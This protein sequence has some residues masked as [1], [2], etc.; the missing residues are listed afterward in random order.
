M[1]HHLPAGWGTF[2]LQLNTYDFRV[3]SVL[4]FAPEGTEL[5]RFTGRTWITN[6]KGVSGWSDPDMQLSLAEGY[7]VR[8]R[9]PTVLTTVGEFPE[10][11]L[12]VMV[13]RGRHWRGSLAPQAGL[14]SSVLL[15]PAVPGLRVFTATGL[16]SEPELALLAEYRE[17]G[18]HPSEPVLSAG[19]ALLFESPQT[20]IWSRQF[21]LNGTPQNPPSG[22]ADQPDSSVVSSGEDATFTAVPHIAGLQLQW[23]HNGVDL[24]GETNTTLTLTD[25]QREDAGSYWLRLTYAGFE[26][27][28]PARLAVVDPASRLLVQ[29]DAFGFKRLVPEVPA[30]W[31]P[32]LESSVN[33]SDWQEITNA[34]ANGSYPLPLFP[35]E[36]RRH[37]RLRL[38]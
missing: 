33:F 24:P 6:V 38:E 26:F 31:T 22:F 29:Q 23:Q 3:G 2:C 21:F 4:E 37:F 11:N 32:G 12:K 13:P 27:S 25:V 36:P 35:F 7:A 15:F 14:L 19:Q 5:R 28:E 8:C 34:F 9:Q 18:W 20:L 30:G 16:A 1:N 17:Q 10:G